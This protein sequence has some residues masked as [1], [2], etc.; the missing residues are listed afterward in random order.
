MDSEPGSQVRSPNYLAV[1]SF[2][3][4]LQEMACLIFKKKKKKNITHLL[5]ADV[6]DSTGTPEQTV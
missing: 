2:G 3:N 1:Q 5:S 6:P 4:S